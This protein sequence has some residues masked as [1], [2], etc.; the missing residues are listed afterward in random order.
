MVVVAGVHVSVVPV[1]EDVRRYSAKCGGEKV[2]RPE[3]AI[4]R[5]PSRIWPAVQTVHED[6]VD[7]G[8]WVS[9]HG[10]GLVPSYTAVL[11]GLKIARQSCED[12]K[13]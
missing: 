3:R 5:S 4:G 11:N 7:L 9:I 8:A 10:S 2:E 6:D 13:K 1:H 12:L